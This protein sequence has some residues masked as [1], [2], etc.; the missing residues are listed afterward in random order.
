[1]APTELKALMVSERRNRCS[2]FLRQI[3]DT[4]I[5]YVD[6][7]R[8]LI[9]GSRARGGERVTSDY[10]LA[11]AGLLRPENWSR[12]VLYLDEHAETLLPFDLVC[13]EDA[14]CALRAQIDEDGII[15][16]ERSED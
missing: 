5:D 7:Q 12:F 2:R 3:I 9:F 14:S 10:D 13:Y 16:Y 11:F 1:M 15:L 4:A 8:I 6:P